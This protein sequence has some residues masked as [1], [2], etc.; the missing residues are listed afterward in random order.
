MQKVKLADYL[1]NINKVKHRR[2]EQGKAETVQCFFDSCVNDT[3]P[4]EE[5][6][7]RWHALLKRYSEEDK[8]VFFL[9]R[10]ASDGNRNWNNIRRGFLT[11]YVDGNSYV[12]CDNFFAHYFYAMAIDNYVPDYPDFLEVMHERKFPYGFMKTSA[13]V[14]L[15]AYY[16]GKNP[17]IN[18]AGWKLAHI[19]SVNG[20]DY[21]YPYKSLIKE[22]FPRGERDEWQQGEQGYV[23]RHINREMSDEERMLLKSHFLRLTH[24]LNY[25][26]VPMQK[27]EVNLFGNDIGELPELINYVLMHYTE[28]YPDLFSEYRELICACGIKQPRSETGGKIISIEYGFHINNT[29]NKN[30]NQNDAT[31]KSTTQN[32]AITETQLMNMVLQYLR[33]GLSFRKLEQEVLHDFNSRGFK[34]KTALNNAGVTAGKKGI[35]SVNS[36]ENEIKYASGEYLDTLQK[37]RDHINETDR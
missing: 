3:L 21:S 17:G 12:F 35:L 27:Y 7:R 37:L 9:R 10:Y 4:T 19:F 16:K 1:H 25:F 29:H 22:H 26:L 2:L 11:E 30:G 32:N 18:N 23:R 13:E 20:N 33:N 5:T 28:K 34:S 36:L 31:R 15:Q 8:C 24:P 6:I 14:P